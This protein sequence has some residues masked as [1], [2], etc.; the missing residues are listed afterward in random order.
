MRSEVKQC[1]A[2]EDS[3]S[4]LESKDTQ[5]CQANSEDL[6]TILNYHSKSSPL[7]QQLSNTE[8]AE[9]EMFPSA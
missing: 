2:T 5:N 9:V 1:M 4:S 8:G 3:H 7:S 6:R